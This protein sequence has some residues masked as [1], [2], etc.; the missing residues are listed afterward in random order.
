LVGPQ[1]EDRLFTCSEDL[2]GLEVE[3]TL[4]VEPFDHDFAHQAPQLHAAALAIGVAVEVEVFEAAVGDL[5]PHLVA[6]P[7]RLHPLDLQKASFE[8]ADKRWQRYLFGEAVV[9]FD[10]KWELEDDFGIGMKA[11]HLQG[12][13]HDAVDG[14]KPLAVVDDAPVDLDGGDFYRSFLATEAY[15]FQSLFDRR[16]HVGNSKR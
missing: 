9:L 11:L 3:P 8:V 10:A 5:A 12:L 1:A 4:L 13:G 7:L 16:K 14:E 15:L 2:T 6:Q